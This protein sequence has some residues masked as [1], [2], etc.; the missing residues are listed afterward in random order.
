[1]YQVPRIMSADFTIQRRSISGGIWHTANG[2]RFRGP[3]HR[4]ESGSIEELRAQLRRVAD[5][6]TL[7]FWQHYRIITADGDPVERYKLKPGQLVRTR[8]RK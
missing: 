6:E 5:T 4:A 2:F 8:R 1:M 3:D 7:S